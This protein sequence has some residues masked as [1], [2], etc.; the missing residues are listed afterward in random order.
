[1]NYSERGSHAQ[2]V[3]P[4]QDT[5]RMRAS[6]LKQEEEN[7]SIKYEKKERGHYKEEKTQTRPN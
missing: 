5:S 4:T 1:M 7:S 2:S 6:R 3:Y